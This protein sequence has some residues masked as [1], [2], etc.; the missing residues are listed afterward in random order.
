MQREMGFRVGARIALIPVL[1]NASDC[2]RIAD[3]S[4]AEYCHQLNTYA[5]AMSLRITDDEVTW[6]HAERLCDQVTDPFASATCKYFFRDAITQRR[7]RPFTIARPCNPLLR[8]NE[9]FATGGCFQPTPCFGLPPDKC[10]QV[11][12]APLGNFPR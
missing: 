12:A 6:A 2:K 10:G 5:A 8:R 4:L 11:L 3:A 9:P 7:S 1:E